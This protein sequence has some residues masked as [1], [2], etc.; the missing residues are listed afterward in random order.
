ME[1]LEIDPRPRS[2]AFTAALEESQKSD[3]TSRGVTDFTGTIADRFAD[4]L[5]KQLAT[6]VPGWMGRVDARLKARLRPRDDI[7]AVGLKG[8]LQ[9]AG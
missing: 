1:F 3:R 6:T 8:W 9:G 2:Y 7:A 4:P 5:D